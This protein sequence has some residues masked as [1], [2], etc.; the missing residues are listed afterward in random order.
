MNILSLSIFQR[1]FVFI[2]ISTD[3]SLILFLWIKSGAKLLIFA[4]FT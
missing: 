4:R 3:F 1:I 2:H